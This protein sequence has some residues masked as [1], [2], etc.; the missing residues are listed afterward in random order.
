MPPW[1]A[2]KVEKRKAEKLSGLSPVG[3]HF[4]HRT[5]RAMFRSSAEGR[6]KG[7]SYRD[8]RKDRISFIQQPPHLPSAPPPE[9]AR[10]EKA[11]DR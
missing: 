9:K 1:R 10:E 5:T 6:M 7:V 8:S 4:S 3:P 11:L 2:G